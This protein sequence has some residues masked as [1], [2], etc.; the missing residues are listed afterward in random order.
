[1]R[2]NK[3]FNVEDRIHLYYSGS[4]NFTEIVNTYNV[5]I[6]H[7]TLAVDITEKDDLTEEFDLNGEL[8]K[9]DVVKK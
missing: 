9:L 4:H 8:V 2:K 6:K 1:M 3:D 5:L 7:E